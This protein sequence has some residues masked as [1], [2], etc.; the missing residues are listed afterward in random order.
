ML[1]I[2]SD[3]AIV[4]RTYDVGE[5]DRFCILLTKENGIVSARA[6]GVRRLTSAR[7]AVLLPLNHLAV[8]FMERSAS[9]DIA[10]AEAITQYGTLA[11]NLPAFACS[12]Q[13]VE[14]AQHFVAENHPAPE[15]FALTLSLLQA[16][17]DQYSPDLL[18]VFTL[19]LLTLLGLL[20]SMT[21]SSLSHRSLDSS[22]TIGFSKMA[23]GLCFSAE[24]SASEP[25]S[26]TLHRLLIAMT[27][28]RLDNLPRVAPALQR[29]LKRF[30]QSVLGSQLGS[31]LKVP[32]VAA[33]L[34]PDAT[35]IW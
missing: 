8:T 24:D 16:C 3:E 7:G 6:H 21:H 34:S 12:V 35:P 13:A 22:D 14:L 19:K 5:A 32:L 17:H 28:L 33:R 31:E 23:G 4:L 25:L 18:F 10:S 9:L 1:K 26:P 2:L 29:E 27:E 30:T 15:I 20:P 11:Q